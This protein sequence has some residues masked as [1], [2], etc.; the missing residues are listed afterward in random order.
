MNEMC[1]EQNQ[2]STYYTQTVP[3]S[4]PLVWVSVLYKLE[5]ACNHYR[6]LGGNATGLQC[7]HIKLNVKFIL[8][9]VVDIPDLA[10]PPCPVFG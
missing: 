4:L 3:G 8:E 1:S 10:K 7:T 5:F 6:L 9:K 2:E